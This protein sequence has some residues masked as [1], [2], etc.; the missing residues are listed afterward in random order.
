MMRAAT[1][2]SL[3][4]GWDVPRSHCAGETALCGS[5]LTGR[6]T[7]GGIRSLR[8]CPEPAVGMSLWYELPSRSERETGPEGW[9]KG[10]FST[11]RTT[12]GRALV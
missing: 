5:D 10:L 3:S 7:V 1:E 4:R 2:G 8:A 12:R 9:S 6:S 11:L